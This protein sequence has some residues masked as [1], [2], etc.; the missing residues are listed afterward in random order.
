[1][2]SFWLVSG[3]TEKLFFTRAAHNSLKPADYSKMKAPRRK[4]YRFAAI[5]SLKAKR[6]WGGAGED[7]GGREAVVK[8]QHLNSIGH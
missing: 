8:S 2:V 7:V 3:K 6:V 5:P 4:A 1:M